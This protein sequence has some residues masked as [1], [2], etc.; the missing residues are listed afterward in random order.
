MAE[1][2]CRGMSTVTGPLARFEVGGCYASDLRAFFRGGWVLGH[3]RPSSQLVRAHDLFSPRSVN[4]APE[5]TLNPAL[6]QH[7]QE[8][9]GSCRTLSASSTPR[10]SFGTWITASCQHQSSRGCHSDPPAS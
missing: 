5:S 8:L 2:P 6:I 4:F 9:D 1:T 7:R 3:L 10:Q